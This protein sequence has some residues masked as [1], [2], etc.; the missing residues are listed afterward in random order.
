MNGQ[1]IPLLG[2]GTYTMRGDI[3]TQAV[4]YAIQLGYRLIDTASVYRNEED[5]AKGIQESGVPRDQIFITSKLK[6]HDHGKGKAREACLGSLKRLQINYIDL[7][8]IHWPGVAGKAP[9]DPELTTIRKETWGEL[10]KLAEEGYIKTLGVSNYMPH[11]LNEFLSRNS[12]TST[13]TPPS[14]HTTNSTTTEKMI[15]SVSDTPSTASSLSTSN[16]IY[17]P[18]VN[19]FELHPLLQQQATIDICK[20]HSIHVQSYATLA[21]GSSELLSNPEI[22]RIATEHHLTPAQV[23]LRWA[24]QHGWSVIPKST[25]TERIYENLYSLNGPDLTEKEMVILDN[26]EQ[27]N[28]KSLRTCWDP[29]GIA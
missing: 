19:Q 16:P 9:T 10:V 5:V 29:T 15:N 8:L 3:C 23:C 22:V 24:I 26:L 6:P 25:H 7:Y 21:R 11:H 20:Q 12:T 27:T 14:S 13:T 1:E 17:Y 18:L 4:K 2:L 28:G